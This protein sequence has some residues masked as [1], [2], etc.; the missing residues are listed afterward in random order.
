MDNAQESLDTWALLREK[1]KAGVARVTMFIKCLVDFSP[2]VSTDLF[3]S[4]TGVSCKGNQPV[5]DLCMSISFPDDMVVQF[6][7]AGRCR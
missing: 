2:S 6:L 7:A 1:L 5:V 3:V 4:S